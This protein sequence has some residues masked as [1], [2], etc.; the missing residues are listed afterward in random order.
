MADALT[1]RLMTRQEVDI[2]VGWA[3]QEGW[4]PGLSDADVFWQTDPEG[5]IA[6]EIDGEL[7]GGGSV[8]SYGGEFGF[9]GLFIVRPEFRGH[10]FGDRLWHARL[11]VL[12]SR[13]QAGAAI[14]IDGVFTMQDW[15]ARGGF[16]FSHRTIRYEGVGA[17][18]D[19]AAGILPAADVSRQQL[20]AY[21]RRCFP[22][23]RDHF[24]EGWLTQPDSLALAAVGGAGLRGYG[25]VRRCGRGTKIGPLFADDADIAEDL[26]AAL[27]AY[28]PDEPLFID[29][30]EI[31][32]W[33]MSLAARQGMQEVFGCA[34][35]YLGA[36]PQVA[37]ARIYGS[38][39]FELG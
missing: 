4:N 20:L 38:T 19:R 37:D 24:L 22:A 12:R 11:T 35:M 33:A 39:S 26:F 31:N 23:P 2:L 15:Y 7:I 3:A 5:F 29:V 8:T 6:A 16:D 32:A 34:R 21:D 10:G 18:A 28:G 9:M 13:L 14:G 17:K 36:R 27:A 30:P 25:V 1:L